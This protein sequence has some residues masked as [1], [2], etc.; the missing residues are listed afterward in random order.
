[1]D[2]GE[3]MELAIIAMILLGIGF[4]IWRGGAANPVGTGIVQHKLK[5]V[6]QE[7][8]AL[9]TGY[10]R[11]DNEIRALRESAASIEGIANLKEALEAERRRTDKIFESIEGLGSDI[12]ALREQQ[13]AKN[14]IVEELSRSVRALTSELATYQRDVTER[15]DALDAMSERISGNSRAISTMVGQIASIGEKQ[16]AVA[17]TCAATSS[18]LK[19]VGRQVDRLYDVIVNKGLGN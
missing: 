5:N 2:S 10:R 13:A 6:S 8:H 19:Q 12:H 16:N 3:M 15:L 17:E 9:D 11:L 7:V 4:T 1:M 18:D 14:S